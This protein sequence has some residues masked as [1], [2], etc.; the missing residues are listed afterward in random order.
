MTGT[1]P[2]TLEFR[3]RCEASGTDSWGGRT[4][5][6]REVARM[7]GGLM[8]CMRHSRK[9]DPP[10]GL[11]RLLLYDA[12]QRLRAARERQRRA[13]QVLESATYRRE[14]LMRTFEKPTLVEREPTT[15][16]HERTADVTYVGADGTPRTITVTMRG[17]GSWQEAAVVTAP[18]TPW[19]GQGGA[20]EQAMAMAWRWLADAMDGARG[21]EAAAL[22]GRID[23]AQAEEESASE[24]LDRQLLAYERTRA[25]AEALGGLR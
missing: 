23:A 22:L 8:R 21:D 15:K 3:P 2:R 1:D 9:E 6:G 10:V 5:C 4:Y 13:A 17:A 24:A 14:G 20:L 11:G 19:R 18:M 7:H 25:V 12:D 16:P